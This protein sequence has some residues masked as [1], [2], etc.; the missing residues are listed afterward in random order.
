M[1]PQI[2]GC[3]D[4]APPPVPVDIDILNC[5]GTTTTTTFTEAPAQ[6]EIVQTKPF[7]ICAENPV[8][9]EVGGFGGCY[10]G[11]NA[12]IEIVRNED[13]TF[14]RYVAHLKDGSGTIVDPA[15]PTQISECPA[16]T[17]AG[18]TNVNIDCST[19][20]IEDYSD[21]F[22]V[23]IPQVVRVKN[24]CEVEEVDYI[25]TNWLPI[26]VDGIQW[27]VAEEYSFNNTTE[28][29]TLIGKIYKEGA[30]GVPTVILPIGSIIDGACEIPTQQTFRSGAV[31]IAE[32]TFVASLGPDGVIWI[33]PGSLRSVTVRA[34]RSN[35]ND[36]VPGSGANQVMVQTTTNKVVLLTNESATWSVEDGNIQDLDRVECLGNSAA[37][38]IYNFL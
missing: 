33:N 36:A 30:N 8:Q 6:V 12:H 15:L 10:S 13:G 17:I 26:C 9:I 31:S 1:I 5:D 35:N 19:T 29:K 20:S 21:T 4:E 37:L 22:K 38:V 28:T 25:H 14:N 34:R 7:V 18:T 2:I 23:L 27:Y 3:C 24:E 32:G 11:V 16:N